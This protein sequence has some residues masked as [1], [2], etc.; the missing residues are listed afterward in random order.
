MSERAESGHH[1][2]AY[3]DEYL[4]SFADGDEA[5]RELI[6]LGVCRAARIGKICVKVKHL[7]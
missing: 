3:N 2:L 4:A 1:E 5:K 7:L 6:Q